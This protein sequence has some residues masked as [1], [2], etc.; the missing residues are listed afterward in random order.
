M[1]FDF[2]E[3]GVTAMAPVLVLLLVFDRLDIFNLIT[4]RTI[5]LMVLI[6]GAIAGVSYYANGGVENLTHGFPIPGDNPYSLYIAPA[7]EET[8]KAVPIVAMFAMNRLGFKLDAAIAGFAIGA[9]FSMV[10]NA[11]YL[12]HPDVVGAAYANFSAWLVRGFGT[13]IMHGGATALFAAASH[14]MSETQVQADAARYRFNPLLFLP[15]LAGAYVLHSVFNHFRDQSTLAMALTLLLVPISLF[16]ILSRS[17]RATHA[18]IKADHDAHKTML[19]DIRSG[20]FA[21]SEMGQA[22]KRISDRFSPGIANDVF[23]Y[24]ETK[25]ELVLRGEEIMLAVQ[26]GEE[27]A[28]G[29]AER[30][31]VLRLE[32][33]EHK[34]GPSV[35]AAIGPKLGFSRNDLWELEH[36]KKRAKSLEAPPERQP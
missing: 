10:E 24:L 3:K 27:A 26:E 34:I 18:W 36:L 11:V 6:G 25:T 20:H 7:V 1:D 23:A 33:L 5:A 12:V 16:F 22:L 35:L 29:P 9:G 15:G 17:E 8:L 19:D 2:I 21:Q 28:V 4:M 32:S 14:E 31:K 30:E 13:A